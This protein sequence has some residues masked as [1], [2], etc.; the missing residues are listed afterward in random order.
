MI[1]SIAN[2]KGGVGKTA[3]SAMLALELSKDHEVL[4]IDADPQGSLTQWAFGLLAE[5]EVS[6]AYSTLRKRNLLS[7]LT[8]DSSLSESRITVN[9]HLKIIGAVSELE[10]FRITANSTNIGVEMI[11]KG[12][13]EDY[14]MTQKIR[15]S[16]V[17]S[18]IL[19]DTAGDLS[20]LSTQ[21]LAASQSVVIPVGTQLMPV[22]SLGLTLSKVGQVQK[23]LNYNLRNIVV[24]PTLFHS[25]RRT[26][27]VSLQILKEQYSEIVLKD[28]SD[29]ILP[30]HNRAEIENL[31][32]AHEPLP[33]NAQAREALFALRQALNL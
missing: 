21:A 18:V 27:K 13:L 26:N 3:L 20:V 30:I 5:E 22:D 17:E 10:R 7:V 11:L 15:E 2:V 31:L 24:V 19:I 32:H 4:L 1:I 14:K 23:Y 8:A 28:E 6:Q 29:E 33:K 25:L 16:D 12:A 9:P